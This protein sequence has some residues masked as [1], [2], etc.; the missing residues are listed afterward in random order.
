MVENVFTPFLIICFS[1]LSQL[2]DVVKHIFIL[3]KKMMISLIKVFPSHCFNLGN[4]ETYTS[5]AIT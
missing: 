3:H 2:N 4:N 5:D 1:I